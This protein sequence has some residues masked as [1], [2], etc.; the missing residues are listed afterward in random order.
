M[1]PKPQKQGAQRSLLLLIAFN[2]LPEVAVQQALE[3]LAV[4]GLVTLCIAGN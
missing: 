2:L 3:S 1:P 4:A